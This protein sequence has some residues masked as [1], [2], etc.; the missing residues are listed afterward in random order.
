M[1]TH[2][3]FALTLPNELKEELHSR[4]EKL[5]FGFLFKKWLHPADYHITMAFLGEASET[6]RKE[7]VSL[8]QTALEN[9]MAFELTLNKMGTFGR[10]DRPRILWADVDFNPRLFDVQSKVY[11]ACKDAGF[12]LDSKPFKPH[13]TLARKYIGEADFSLERVSDLVTFENTHFLASK[14]TLYQTHIGEAPSYEPIVSIK[15]Q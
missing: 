4:I 9:E 2:F 8:I 1:N 3:F 14:I 5:K 11:Q 10:M 6:M 7:A 15:L 13:I 12:T